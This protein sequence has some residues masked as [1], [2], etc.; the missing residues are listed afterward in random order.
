MAQVGVE[1][2]A[3][4]SK[5]AVEEYAGQ[6]PE[7]VPNGM[8]QVLAGLAYSEFLAPTSADEDLVQ[9]ADLQTALFGIMG[10]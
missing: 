10:L 4:L 6:A 2:V 3:A 5:V 9:A 7:R 1:G 8:D